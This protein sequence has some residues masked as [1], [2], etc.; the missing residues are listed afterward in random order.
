MFTPHTIQWTPE[1]IARFWDYKYKTCPIQFNEH[2]SEAL[3]KIVFKH[4]PKPGLALD[5]GCGTGGLLDALLKQGI[6]AC[7]YDVSPGAEAIVNS[8]FGINPNYKGFFLPTTPC[9]AV[10]LTEV[11]EHIPLGDLHETFAALKP[12]IGPHTYVVIT[13]PYKEKLEN[14]ITICPDCGATFNTRQHVES[15]DE[16]KLVPALET[17]GLKK[18]FCKPIN[19]SDNFSRGFLKRGYHFLTRTPHDYPTLL[20]I[21]LNH[22]Q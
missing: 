4:I 11:V 3:L 20:Y 1:V 10:F 13:V 8:R 16:D 17:C 14:Y 9:D 21:G 5:Y 18:V 12:A 6:D 7:G 22:N 19:L 15:Y 2:G